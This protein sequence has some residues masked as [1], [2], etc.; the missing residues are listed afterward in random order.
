MPDAKNPMSN[1]T[2]EQLKAANKMIKK[3]RS[4]GLSETE[5]ARQFELAEAMLRYM[6]AKGGTATTEELEAFEDEWLATN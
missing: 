4:A 2:N 1:L 5:I 3:M 6:D